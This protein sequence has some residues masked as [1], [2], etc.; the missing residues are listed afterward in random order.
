MICHDNKCIF[1]HIPKTAGTSIEHSFGKITMKGSE[2]KKHPTTKH[3]TLQDYNLN[4]SDQFNDYFKFT[5]VRNPWEREYSLWRF[6]TQVRQKKVRINKIFNFF[7][8]GKEKGVS[9]TFKDYLRNLEKDID[10]YIKESGFQY[11]N[12]FRDQYEFI[13]IENSIELDKIIRYERLQMGY[14]EVCERL[15]RYSRPLPKIYYS[16]KTT[17]AEDFDQESIDLVAKLRKRDIDFLGYQF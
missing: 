12:L 9:H 3:H 2:V 4:Y 10:F 15:D 5:V 1:I 6:M 17:H 13:N 8:K 7:K 14:D 11:K 16:G